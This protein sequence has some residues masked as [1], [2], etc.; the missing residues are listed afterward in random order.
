[1]VGSEE[2][3]GRDRQAERF[4]GLEVDDQ[5]EL[6]W[7]LDRPVGGGFS[8]TQNVIAR[9]AGLQAGDRFNRRRARI[10]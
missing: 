4:R 5:L 9:V 3:R 10:G 7:L 1:V 2:Q 8:T 6:R